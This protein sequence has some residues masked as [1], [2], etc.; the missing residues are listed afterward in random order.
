LPYAH[1]HQVAYFPTDGTPLRYRQL[2]SDEFHFNSASANPE[3]HDSVPAVCSSSTSTNTMITS[4]AP[5]DAAAINIGLSQSPFT[6]SSSSPLSSLSASNSVTSLPSAVSSHSLSPPVQATKLNS[7]PSISISR[8]K[9]TRRT[10]HSKFRSPTHST[11]TGTSNL[12][13]GK[14]SAVSTPTPTHASTR[15][16][17]AVAAASAFSASVIQKRG[18]SC[19][20]CK[21]VKKVH[22]CSNQIPRKTSGSVRRTGQLMKLCRKKYCDRC[23]ARSYN[24]HFPTGCASYSVQWICPSCRGKC[25]CA[26]CTRGRDRTDIVPLQSVSVTSSPAPSSSSSPPSSS[27]TPPPL[28]PAIPR[29]AGPSSEHSDGSGNGADSEN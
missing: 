19:H 18:S 20:Q 27:A 24:E 10:G 9:I 1:G 29:Q 25:I 3:S 8:S 14:S 5:S 12:S 28:P 16:T 2:K 11:K 7:I 22:G 13:K 6:S 21:N 4:T 17:R 23:L 15:V 26:V